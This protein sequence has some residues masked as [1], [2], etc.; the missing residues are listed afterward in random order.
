MAVRNHLLAPIHA[1]D[2]DLFSSAAADQNG[3]VAGYRIL[4][5]D[6]HVLSFLSGLDRLGWNN[7]AFG[8]IFTVNQNIGELTRPELVVVVCEKSP[9]SR[10]VPVVGSTALSMKDSLPTAVCESPVG[11]A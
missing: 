6:E 8:C 11:V 4:P 9:S 1:A 7:N 2:D 10:M 3:P 5:H